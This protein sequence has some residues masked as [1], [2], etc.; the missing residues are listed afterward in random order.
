MT[1]SD[2]RSVLTLLGGITA[3]FLL[4][5]CQARTEWDATRE[6][7]IKEHLGERI[8]PDALKE[9]DEETSQIIQEGRDRD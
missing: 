3:L 6:G 8:T 5:R 7:V 4:Y 1:S 9:I 2:R